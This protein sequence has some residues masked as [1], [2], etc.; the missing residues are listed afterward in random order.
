M[1]KEKTPKKEKKERKKLKCDFKTW[2]KTQNWQKIGVIGISVILVLSIEALMLKKYQIPKLTDG[3]EVVVELNGL[4]ITAED[5]Y[6][7]L[8]GEVGISSITNQI[9]E[10]IIDDKYPTT[11]EIEANV[12]EYV[13]Y[14]KLQTG[15]DFL[16]YVSYYGYGETEADFVK[17]VTRDYKVSLLVTDYIKENIT[18]K[19]IEDYYDNTA[20]GD[21]E[22]SHI[23]IAPETTDDMTTAEITEA[24][25]EAYALAEEIIERLDDG[26]DFAD[27]AAEYSADTSN[28]SDGGYLGYISKDGNMVQ[29]FEDA[30]F[31]LKDGKYSKTPVETTYGYHIIYRTATATKDTLED[32]HDDIIDILVQKEL[33][34]NT[35]ITNEAIAAVYN[36]YN[37]K[38]TD[39]KLGDEFKDAINDL[40]NTEE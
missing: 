9:D 4:T 17:Y 31:A 2:I 5:L 30:A 40:L 15:D 13:E 32:M 12:Q 11:D 8:K 37:V 34:E 35:N 39:S 3:T 22:V 19:D 28:S 6:E 20:T 38:F 21:I 7:K 18:E 27:L 14:F 1:K 26:E 16:S 24:E 25:E 23:L 33:D 29:E 36:E 10:F